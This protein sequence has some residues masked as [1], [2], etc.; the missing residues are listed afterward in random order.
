M[1]RTPSLVNNRNALSL[2]AAALMTAAALFIAFAPSRFIPAAP[3]N[4]PVAPLPAQRA[5]AAYSARL[6]GVADLYAPVA[7]Y[8]ARW[9]GLAQSYKAESAYA[10]RWAGLSALPSRS[11]VAYAAR[12][13]GMAK[14]Y[15]ATTAYAAEQLK[16][17]Q[18]VHLQYLAGNTAVSVAAYAARSQGLA[19]LPSRG[20]VAYAARWAGAAQRYAAVAAYAARWEGTAQA[21]RQRSNAAWA[22]RWEGLAQRYAQR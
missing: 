18:A 6:Q 2:V 8:G 21:Y 19:E 9:T 3:A 22:A 10:A 1:I 4:A 20:E 17:A 5:D 15:T 12:W 13:N 7:A 14:Q 16:R 11:V